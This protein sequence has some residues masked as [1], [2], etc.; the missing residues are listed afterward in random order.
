MERVLRREEVTRLATE[1]FDAFPEGIT[2]LKFYILD[3]GC[4]YFQLVDQ[5]GILDPH[6][7]V[8]RGG[9][10]GPCQICMLQ[11]VNWRQMVVDCVVIYRFRVEVS[12][13]N[14]VLF[15]IEISMN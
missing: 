13:S 1:I 2:G 11:A 9:K 4:L 12:G 6:I 7:A 5:D 15:T 10:E 3:C 8:Y 14:R